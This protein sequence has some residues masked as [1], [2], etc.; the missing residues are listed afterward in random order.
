MITNEAANIIYAY[1][2][3]TIIKNYRAGVKNIINTANS[4]Y[5]KGK[6]SLTDIKHRVHFDND[7]KLFKIKY[8]K[9]DAIAVKSFKLEAF[10]VGNVGEYELNEKLKQLYLDLKGDKDKFYNESQQLMLDYGIGLEDQMPAGWLESQMVTAELRSYSSSRWI[11][12][13]DPDISELYPAVKTFT[14]G[15]SKVRAS[16]KQMYEDRVY[17]KSDP[18]LPAILPP[19]LGQYRC[20]CTWKP[21]A[22][23]EVESIDDIELIKKSDYKEKLDFENITNPADI[24]SIYQGYLKGKFKDLPPDALKDIRKNLNAF[25]KQL[26]LDDIIE[27]LNN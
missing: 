6:F 22:R 15:D 21:A 5:K 19:A 3:S 13:N 25:S 23:W 11:K 7:S 10:A 9:N 17:L 12:A 27:E 1:L 8:T 16:H 4:D 26:N 14:R 24:N 20:R 2:N 18:N